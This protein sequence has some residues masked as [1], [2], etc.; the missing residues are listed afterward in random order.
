MPRR[1]YTRHRPRPQQPAGTAT[2][3]RQ[4]LVELDWMHQQTSRR[5]RERR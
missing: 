4:L 2:W 3:I 5:T 1:N